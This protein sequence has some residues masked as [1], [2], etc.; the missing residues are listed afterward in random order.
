MMLV[1]SVVITVLLISLFN[2]KA[3]NGPQE[4][5]T[6]DNINFK[7]CSK[8]IHKCLAMY[9]ITNVMLLIYMIK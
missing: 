5:I 3:V 8:Y 9:I 4:L 1:V 2:A 7:D 6:G